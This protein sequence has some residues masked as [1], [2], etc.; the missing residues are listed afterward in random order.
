MCEEWLTDIEKQ[1]P[2]MIIIAGSYYDEERHN[3]CRMIM[4]SNRNLLPPLQDHTV[5][6]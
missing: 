4:Y 3:V 1:Y 2:E 5:G 6:I